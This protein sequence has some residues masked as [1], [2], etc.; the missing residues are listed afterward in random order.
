MNYDIIKEG[1]VIDL[2]E[3]EGIVC[4][5]KVINGDLYLNIAFEEEQTHFQ[6]YQVAIQNDSVFFKKVT[7]PKIKEELTAQ[8]IAEELESSNNN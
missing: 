7:N 8:W 1:Q 6:I 3:G 5:K 2:K 4:F